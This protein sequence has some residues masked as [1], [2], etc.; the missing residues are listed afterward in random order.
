MKTKIRIKYGLSSYEPTSEQVARWLIQVRA[1]TDSGVDPEEAG[2]KAARDVFSTYR[3][4][5]R[6]SQADT[7]YDLLREITESN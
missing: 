7:I 1:Q 5:I 2:E 4:H 3:T 6:D